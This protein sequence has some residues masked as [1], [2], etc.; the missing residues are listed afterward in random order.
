MAQ[1]GFPIAVCLL[2]GAV[3]LVGSDAIT[4]LAMLVGIVQLG[5]WGSVAA[6]AR[7]QRGAG[8]WAATLVTASFGLALLVLK[9]VVH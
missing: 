5:V 3:G 1:A 7:G 8:R 2:L 6:H 9:V 4:Y